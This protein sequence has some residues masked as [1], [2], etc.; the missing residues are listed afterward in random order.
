MIQT[1]DYHN[2]QSRLFK[3]AGRKFFPIKAMVELT[4]RCNLKCRHCYVAPQTCYR[5]R[6]ELD[7]GQ[8]FNILDQLTQAGCLNMGFTG[9]E[10]FLREDIFE[11]LAHAKKKGLNIVILTNGTLIT[12][13]KADRLERLG[14]NKI[15]I[16]F[17][18]VNRDTFDWFTQKAGTYKKVMNAIEL[19]RGRGIDV[20]LKT[21]A[22]TINKS[23]LV[24]MRHFAVEKFGAHFRLGYEVSPDWDGRKDALEFALTPE[25]IRHTIEATQEDTERQVET[26][27]DSKKKNRKSGTA[28]QRVYQIPHHRLFRCGAGRTEA[29][30]GPYGD[31]RLCLDIHDPKYNMLEIGFFAIM[32]GFIATPPPPPTSASPEDKIDGII[33]TID[34]ALAG[35][36]CGKVHM[37][38]LEQLLTMAAH[39]VE[40]GKI[41]KACNKLDNAYDR[42][43]KR[44]KSKKAC[45]A[46]LA[47][48]IQDQ[49][50]DVMEDL[51]CNP[52]SCRH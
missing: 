28:I 46:Q 13:D 37:K 29:V 41:K 24:K 9:G 44:L 34:E 47:A 40:K 49:I 3:K 36:D 23:E 50:Q 26:S 52:Q 1:L 33:D 45:V 10:P 22:M 20:Y 8:V 21:T 2:L 39:A 30:I 15:D 18:T 4:Y 42:V 27:D 17:H 11:I 12:P 25:E 38:G 7:T 16:S 31:I 14:L 32:K 5:G 43:S 6:K 51:E 19:L 35:G 48:E